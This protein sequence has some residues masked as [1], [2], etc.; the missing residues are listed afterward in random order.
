MFRRRLKHD[1]S[2]GED[3]SQQEPHWHL[4]VRKQPRHVECGVSKRLRPLAP[5]PHQLINHHISCLHFQQLMNIS[6]RGHSIVYTESSYHRLGAAGS[7][8]VANSQH[9]INGQLDL[10]TFPSI[11]RITA[12]P[13]SW[14]MSINL[15]RK[16]FTDA[17]L[18][19]MMGWRGAIHC[20]FPWPSWRPRFPTLCNAWRA[21]THNNIHSMPTSPAHEL[22]VLAVSDCTSQSQRSKGFLWPSMLCG[23]LSGP[24]LAWGEEEVPLGSPSLMLGLWTAVWSQRAQ[25]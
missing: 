6:P 14:S 4:M 13:M 5:A 17:T 11:P 2:E 22:T 8:P 7:R 1:M 19:R 20:S 23:P 25:R 18:R 24:H 16:S 15:S 21:Q 9:L 12:L 3:V 10:W